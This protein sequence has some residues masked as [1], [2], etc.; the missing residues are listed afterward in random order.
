MGTVNVKFLHATKPRNSTALVATEPS[1]ETECLLKE[2][3]SIL[4][5]SFLIQGN[6]TTFE[7][8]SIP[9]YNYCYV[10]EFHRYYFITQVASISSNIWQIDCEVDVL[11][12]YRSEIRETKAFIKRAQVGYNSM[13]PDGV[14]TR[15]DSCAINSTDIAFE[16]YDANGCYVLSVLGQTESAQEGSATYY[17]LNSA[18]MNAFMKGLNQ[19]EFWEEIK[20]SYDN[21]L[22]NIASC[23]WL[24]MGVAWCTSTRA[25]ALYLG[26][27]AVPDC[28]PWYARLSYSGN[29]QVGIKVPYSSEN[30]YADYRNVEPYFEAYLY[31]VGVGMVQIPMNKLILGG[32]KY[33]TIGVNYT[34]DIVTG[35][36][37]YQLYESSK[38]SNILMTAKGNLATPIAL[39]GST[40]G[41]VSDL[42]NFAGFIGST[43]GFLGS[44][45]IGN[46][47]GMAEHGADAINS[48]I[49]I[50]LPNQQSTHIAGSTGGRASVRFNDNFTLITTT[51]KTSDSPSNIG[52]TV[53]RPV[54]K[55]GTLGNYTGYVSA[56]GAYVRC[57]A[58]AREHELIEKFVN[59]GVIIE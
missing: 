43:V 40:T 21:P 39:S 9:D 22:D 35:D 27:Y 12:S 6:E 17:V 7:G 49:G 33:P 2:T 46:A 26:N 4:N 16:P 47:V 19:P 15:T 8:K 53:G 29:L 31:L 36:I 34:I 11:A 30:S 54:Q 58:T 50:L 3:T 52:A 10:E 32:T 51:W 18:Q 48:A 23:V 13:I 41:A 25:P 56:V 42:K 37:F 28:V 57:N 20:Q 38:E 44:Q 55:N 24:P 45:A 14:L 1:T 5:P 59:G